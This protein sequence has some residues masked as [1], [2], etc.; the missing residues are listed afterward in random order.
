MWIFAPDAFG[1]IA[2]NWR[3]E[4]RDPTVRERTCVN[5]SSASSP[6][7]AQS[8]RLDG[9]R[10]LAKSCEIT[11][12]AIVPR[13]VRQT[14]RAASAS[15]SARVSPISASKWSLRPNQSGSG[16]RKVRLAI[17]RILSTTAAVAR[18]QAQE[19]NPSQAFSSP[20]DRSAC[21]VRQPDDRHP[22]RACTRTLAV[23]N[24]LD[25]GDS[26]AWSRSWHSIST[27]CARS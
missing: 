19:G 21:N 27:S 4:F 24:G 20:N 3:S 25:I 23:G 15:A 11:R 12:S 8:N 2:L 17:R 7:L 18:L 10:G 9:S 5:L 22:S 1:A 16:R 26:H 14:Q 13:G 6:T